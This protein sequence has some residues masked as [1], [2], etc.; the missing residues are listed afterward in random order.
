MIAQ[1]RGWLQADAE[2][3][4]HSHPEGDM[5]F[6]EKRK[7]YRKPCY[8]YT[9]YAY[10]GKVYRDFIKNIST[11]GAFIESSHTIPLG[12]EVVLTYSEPVSVLPVKT[13]P[14]GQEILVS[15]TEPVSVSP[16]KKTGRVAWVGPGGFGVKFRPEP[17]HYSI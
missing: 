16:V 10:R 11:G 4:G 3:R 1:R 7:S 2:I 5:M 17:D 15:F 9:D 12:Q 14:V 6:S 13:S 8:F